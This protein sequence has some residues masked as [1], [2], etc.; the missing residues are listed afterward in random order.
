MRHGDI[1]TSL[2]VY[3]VTDEM[4][5]AQSKVTGLALNS[6]RSR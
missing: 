1:R 5:E 3:V 4:A 6:T 2:N